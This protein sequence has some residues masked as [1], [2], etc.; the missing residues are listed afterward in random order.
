MIINKKNKTAVDD[1]GSTLPSTITLR[2]F[3]NAVSQLDLSSV[4]PE[5]KKA[6][7]KAHIVKIASQHLLD[8][9]LA[10]QMQVEYLAN[11]KR[12]H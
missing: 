10:T 2:D 5:R 12:L 1:G 8:R 4:P 11:L 6:A 7:L 3:G 9:E